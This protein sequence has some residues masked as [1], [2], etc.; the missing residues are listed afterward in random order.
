MFQPALVPGLLQT[1]E[2]ARAVLSLPR[3][4]GERDLT[5]AVAQRMERQTILYDDTRQFRFLLMEA[6]L[7]TRLVRASAML[8]QLEHIATVSRL[9][10]VE[11]GI[12]PYEVSVPEV[13]SNA[14]VLLDDRVVITETFAGEMVQ[15]DPRDVE[16]HAGIFEAF[17][18]VALCKGEVRG[19]LADVMEAVS[20]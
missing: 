5:A 13:P 17:A 16:L 20:L 18:A 12:V 4:A 14:I 10:N 2:Y 11:V 7:R 6:V 15:R 3:L 19:R 8:A 9:P 1:P